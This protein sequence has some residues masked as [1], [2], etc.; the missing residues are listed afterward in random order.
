MIGR[1]KR[2][3]F[4]A[5]RD[6]KNPE[7]YHSIAL[8]ALL[9]WV[10]LGA[11]GLSSSAY[12]PDEAFR[13][14]GQHTYLAVGLALATAI[15][16]FVI[17]S[18]YR[19][20][21]EHFPFGGGGYIVAG[22]LLGPRFGAL[23]GSA[24]LVDFILTV[25]VSIASCADQIFS[26][27]PSELH[28]YKL[29]IEGFIIVLLVILNLRG[30]KESILILTPIFVVFIIMHV[31]LILY[32][33]GSHVGEIPRVTGEM[34]TG[35]RNGLGTL[36]FFGMAALF[37]RAFSMGAGTFTGIEA[38]SNGL[39]IMREPKVETGK[40]TMTYI[41]V[42]LAIT[43]AGIMILYLLFH[44]TPVDGKTMNAVLLEKFAGSWHWIGLPVGRYFVVI[45]LASEAALLFVAAQAGFI[46]GP[47]VMANMAID[48]WLPRRYAQLSDRLTMQ[49]G[50]LLMGGAALVVLIYT[51]GNITALVTM[52]SINVFLTFSLSMI[53][54]SRYWI[55]ERKKRPEWKSAFAIQLVGLLVC[56]SILTTV[57]IEKFTQGAWMTLVVTSA[58]VAICF[59]IRRHY[60]QVGIAIRKLDDIIK[61]MPQK[62]PDT[63]PELDPKKP[64]AAMLVGGFSGLGVHQIFQV[65]RMFPNQFSNFLFLSTGVIDSATMKGIEEVELIQNRTE[66]ALKKYV[67][68][69]HRLGFAAD[70]RMSM[71]TEAVA[72]LDKLCH[73]CVKEYPRA[74]FFMGKLIFEKET[75]YH[76]ILHN[77]SAYQL[78]RRL[79]L[80]G[81]SAI[82]LTVRLPRFKK[83]VPTQPVVTT[84][85]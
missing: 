4:G 12:G 19:G 72:E 59:A 53:G 31:I 41:S 75:W 35:F 37:L 61:A 10:G 64:T 27:L 78:Q 43:A 56:I 18:A 38:V 67:V 45:A 71:G 69:A 49:N 66:D 70:Y 9:A 33:I 83:P 44:V 60:N 46:G 58:L 28:Q 84:G 16:V 14:L 79:H 48:G 81:L 40:R 55:R 82:V 51:H 5:P 30:V 74:I 47:R 15:T 85:A 25:A 13:A 11:D 20:I 65:Q 36:G 68:L 80:G 7:T 57:V 26:V 39:Q 32:G 62:D 50:V 34:Q 54:M 2:V 63:L 52:Y 77:E 3:L 23:S 6:I 1:I 22:Q 24:L 21:I 8:V 73:V 76:R 17:S 29:F 42:S